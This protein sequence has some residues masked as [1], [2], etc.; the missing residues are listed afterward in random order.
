[1]ETQTSLWAFELQMPLN[2][3]TKKGI[4]PKGEVIFPDYHVEIRLPLH[5]GGEDFFLKCRKSFRA[6]HGPK[7]NRKL[8]HSN[9][10]RMSK[11]TDP[12]GKKVMTTKTCLKCL[13][14][15]EETEHGQ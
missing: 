1:M 12:S 2:Q 5:N 6:S 15:L 7:D 13:K 3:Q 14:R 4:T 11:Y 8:Q 10:G 9:P